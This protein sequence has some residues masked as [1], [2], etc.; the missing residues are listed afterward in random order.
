MRFANLGPST[1]AGRWSGW[2]LVA[3]GGFGALFAALVAAGERGGETFFSNMA[4]TV[5]FLGAVGAAIT[6]GILGV[7]AWRHRDHSLVV[8]VAIVV[9]LFV[10]LWTAAELLFPH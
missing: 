1:N 2:L 8:V 5:P 3:F 4:L 6:A 7:S 10:A 9:G